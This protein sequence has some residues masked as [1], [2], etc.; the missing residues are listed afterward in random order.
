MDRRPIIIIGGAVALV[1]SVF[2]V[3]SFL[4]D[5]GWRKKLGFP[6]PTALRYGDDAVD[7][8]SE[9]SFPASDPP[10]FTAMTAGVGA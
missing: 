3:R 8:S 9:D 5:P 1:A 7:T 6:D 2:A 4:A 10:S